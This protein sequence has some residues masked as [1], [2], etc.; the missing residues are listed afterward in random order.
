MAAVKCGW[1]GYGAK[2]GDHKNSFNGLVAKAVE[3][4]II[5]TINACR[6]NLKQKAIK[7]PDGKVS[8]LSLSEMAGM[9]YSQVRNRMADYLMKSGDYAQANNVRG[10]VEPGF[11]QDFERNAMHLFLEATSGKGFTMPLI[12]RLGAIIDTYSPTEM[13]DRDRV[14]YT[15][16]NRLSD[17]RLE[18]T[19]GDMAKTIL[20]AY[21]IDMEREEF[22]GVFAEN[23]QQ[24]LIKSGVA[25]MQVPAILQRNNENTLEI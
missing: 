3:N 7:K 15:A 22:L 11:E 12:N 2:L 5:E 17:D 25:N 9:L 13:A 16:H 24:Q 10:T 18:V 20:G 8:E 1:Y 4:A 19:A 21:D 6:H 14:I 23:L